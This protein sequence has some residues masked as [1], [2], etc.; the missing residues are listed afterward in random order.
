MGRVLVLGVAIVGLL[1]PRAAALSGQEVIDRVLAV[2]VGD[3]ITLSDVKAATALGLIDP[4]QA[5]DPVREVLSR[6]IDRALILDEVERYV[7]PEPPLEAVEQ[8][9]ARVRTRFDSDRAFAKALA[10][11]G[12]TEPS[13]RRRLREDL[14]IRAYLDQRF[15]ETAP[16]GR[17]TLIQVWLA[18][19][20]RRADILDLYDAAQAAR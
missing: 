7:P 6:L 4:G 10:E 9:L 16:E 2:A 5:T 1:M 19:L 15:P 11:V 20:R 12:L 18:G 3:V 8:A 14:R 17:D 13:L